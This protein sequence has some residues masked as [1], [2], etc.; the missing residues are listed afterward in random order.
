MQA[1]YSRGVD[2]QIIRGRSFAEIAKAGWLGFDQWSQSPRL[3]QD[4][5]T[6]LAQYL[7]SNVN[8]STLHTMLIDV[9]SRVDQYVA[10]GEVDREPSAL[11]IVDLDG[12]G[13][14]ALVVRP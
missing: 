13:R 9:V 14:F 4:V 7:R 3:Q 11:G 12:T 10:C 5:A 1:C 2:Y 8:D 6:V